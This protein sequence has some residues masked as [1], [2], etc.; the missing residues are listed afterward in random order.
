V[1]CAGDGLDAIFR[2]EQAVTVSANPSTAE[3]LAAIR[4][5]AA[6]RVVVLP[7]DPNTHAVAT[8]AAGE[9]YHEGV[10]VRVVPTRSP[11]QAIAALAIRDGAR[12]FEDDVIAMAEAAGKCR[13]AEVTRASR[14]ALTVAGECR[15]GDVIAL[16]EGEVHMIG[17][18]LVALCRDLLDR[19]LGGGGE[20]V[21]LLI[22]E[23]APAELAAEL[24]THLTARWQFAE[25]QCFEGGQPHYPLIVGVE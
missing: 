15:P 12:R 8:A 24:T 1:V 14:E 6:G 17:Q 23:D 7:N 20:L 22:G 9:A 25:V 10:K 21:T 18:D 3:I 5:T 2:G 19:L 11:V 16:V 13:Y 4:K